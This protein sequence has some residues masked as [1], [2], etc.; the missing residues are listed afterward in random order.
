M[1]STRKNFFRIVVFIYPIPYTNLNKTYRLCK[2]VP[3]SVIFYEHHTDAVGARSEVRGAARIGQLSITQHKICE[4]FREKLEN[5]TCQT[6][7]TTH[8]LKTTP[9]YPPQTK[10]MTDDRE[11][12]SFPERP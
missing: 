8:K 6:N 3:S 1:I 10:I 9:K 5:R 4:C 12:Q 7:G 11:Q 2:Y